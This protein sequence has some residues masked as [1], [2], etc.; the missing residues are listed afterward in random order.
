MRKLKLNIL[1]GRIYKKHLSRTLLYTKCVLYYIRII[2][3]VRV[4]F[5]YISH[6]HPLSSFLVFTFFF[7]DF[8]CYYYP[9]MHLFLEIAFLLMYQIV[10]KINVLVSHDTLN[11][12]T[13][14]SLFHDLPLV[15]HHYLYCHFHAVVT[16]HFVNN[17]Q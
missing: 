17:L 3:T 15:Y 16:I 13:L 1:R 5:F 7:Y 10:L 6:Y 9:L 4:L 11:D 12:I 2:R 14:F 8:F